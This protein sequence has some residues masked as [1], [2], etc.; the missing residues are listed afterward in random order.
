VGSFTVIVA[1]VL[2]C[3]DVDYQPTGVTTA[4]VGFEDWIDDVG[5][6]ELVMRSRGAA[7]AYQPGAF[8]ERELPYL[9]AALERMPAMEAIL[10]DAY[11]WLAPDRPGLGKHLH[12]ATGVAIVGV[13]KT[14]FAGSDAIEVVRGT[15]ARPL[16]VTAI[17]VAP[18]V[19]ADRVRAMHGDHRI[20]TLIRRVDALARGRT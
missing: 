4:C 7:A 6:I 12:D 15:S 10:V 2:C 18:A 1:G 16:Y 9:R 8:F 20:P 3:L 5:A 13:A 11:V 17:G 19:A 14:H